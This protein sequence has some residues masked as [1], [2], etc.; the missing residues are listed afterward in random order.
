ML[1][2]KLYAEIGKLLYA[3]ADVDMRISPQGKNKLKEIVSKELIAADTQRDEFG[4]PL[5]YYSEF[6]FEFLDG[7]IMDAETA[8]ISFIDFLEEHKGALDVKM[9]D[10]CMHLARELAQVYYGTNQ[11]EE[12]LL[13]RLIVKLRKIKE[14]QK[15]FS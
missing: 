8:F 11:R 7:E 1:Y 3:V 2:K 12:V 10:L 13:E 4:T 5:A 15:D 14:H 9:T 6:E